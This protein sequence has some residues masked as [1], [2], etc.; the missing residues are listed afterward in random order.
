[1][2]EFFFH[3][4]FIIYLILFYKY[5]NK[6]GSYFKLID[7]PDNMRKSHSL[8]IPSVGGLIIFPYIILSVV[9]IYI[10]SIISFK[11]L[12][13]W[14]FLL[15]SFFFIGLIDDRIN[16]NAK[17]KTFILIFILFITLPLDESFVIKNLVFKDID[18]AI[19]LNEA[20]LFFTIFCIYFFYN[21]LNFSDG[22]NGISISI[23]LY[24]LIVIFLSKNEFNFLY[25]SIILSL[26]LIL[27]PNIF[28][29]IFIGNSGVS[30]LSI[31][32]SILTID[33]YNNGYIY[34]DEIILIFFLPA[35]D[36]ARITIE[37]II[38]GRS[39]FESDK[40]HFHHLLSKITKEKYIFIFYLIFTML[41]FLVANLG[42]SSYLSL[43]LFI[44]LYFFVLFFLKKKNA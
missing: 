30:F 7:F 36:A 16:L 13:L 44:F 32:L 23:S 37:R 3:L 35:I 28:S 9:Y 39:P 31:F 41:P 4:L 21:S 2:N 29:K 40:N 24:F 12:L 10:L 19:V 17:T 27:I 18:L 25:Y 15:S 5:R 38:N 43:S 34:F 8:P 33:F 11:I 14:I 42:V 20:S 22:Y 1:M 6:I 26:I